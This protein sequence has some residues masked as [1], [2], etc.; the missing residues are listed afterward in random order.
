MFSN[1]MK[2]FKVMLSSS[3][4]F[5]RL[6]DSRRPFNTFSTKVTDTEVLINALRELGLTVAVEAEARGSSNTR[7]R[8]NVVAVLEGNCDIG[9]IES[10]ED[11]RT[12]DLVADLWGVSRNH[13]V[14]SLI[15]SITHKYRELEA[16]KDL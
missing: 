2:F 4:E 6:V 11:D 14:H 5:H 10:F 15:D 13:D 7:I 16:I 9:W 12:Y 1:I 8:A 3:P